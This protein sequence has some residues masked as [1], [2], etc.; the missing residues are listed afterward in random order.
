[1]I[2]K[3]PIRC[4]MTPWFPGSQSRQHKKLKTIRIMVR[5]DRSLQVP[6]LPLRKGG[7]AS[8][9]SGEVDPSV[10]AL[11]NSW[12]GLLRTWEE[13]IWDGNVDTTME[14][15]GTCKSMQ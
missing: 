11:A 3:V 13:V 5:C 9:Q 8:S 12:A 1:M 6:S 7:A 14:R 10:C 15:A 2:Y 4:P